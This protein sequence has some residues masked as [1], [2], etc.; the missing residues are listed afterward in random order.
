MKKICLI[1]LFIGIILFSSCKSQKPFDSQ[2]SDIPVDLN[3][4]IS[5][6]IEQNNEN[7]KI[8]SLSDFQGKWDEKIIREGYDDIWTINIDAEQDKVLLSSVQFRY[9][10]LPVDWIIENNKLVISMNDEANRLI[11]ILDVSD[12]SDN[13][14]GTFTQ[15]GIITD[16]TFA[17]LSDIPEIKEFTVEVPQISY[18]ERIQQLNDYSEYKNDGVSIPFTYDLNRRELYTNII[19]EYD[20]DAVTAGYS[21]V[22]LMIVLLNWVCDNFRHNGSSGMPDERDALSIINYCKENPN[23]INC[24]GLAILLAELCRL[25]GIEAKHITCYPKENPCADAHVVTHAYSKELNQWIMLDPTYRLYLK[26]KNDNYINI[27]SL[28]ENFAHNNEIFANEN[29]GWNNTRFIMTEYKEFMVNY[30]FR[31]TC[32]TNFSFGSEDGKTGN[33]VNMLVPTDYSEDR[34]EITTTSINT[35]WAVP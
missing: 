30:L 35:F 8:V 9:N 17:K 4:S 26:D 11:L 7:E 1:I 3:D 6:I 21:D 2:E 34:A 16:V 18:S 23:G 33:I 12:T 10:Y 15:Y 22:E 32:G 5:E 25:Y 20:L 19:E 13:L 27:N 31:F 14:N 24:R 29:A 28:R